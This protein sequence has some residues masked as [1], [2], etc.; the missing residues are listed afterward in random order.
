MNLNQH[1]RATPRTGPA[2]RAL[3]LGMLATAGLTVVA[4]AASAEAATTSHV[5]HGVAVADN[6]V[7]SL[8][9]PGHPSQFQDAFTVHQYGALYDA[10]AVNQAQAQAWACSAASPCRSV[11]LSFQIITMAG[12]NIHLNAQN[13]SHAADHD[14]AGCQTLAGAWQFI[15]ST[16]EPFTLSAAAQRQLADVHRSLDALGRSTAPVTAVQQQADALAAQVESIL[17]AAA[18]TAPKGPGVNALAAHAPV[19]TVHRMLTG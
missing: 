8:A 11:A 12:E 18:A 3:R 10:S 4:T 9:N 17:K 16:P 13:T 5:S 1:R 14:C 2:R 7:F 15:V 6:T 19:V